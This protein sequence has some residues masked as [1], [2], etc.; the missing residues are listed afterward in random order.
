MAADKDA[1]DAR[2]TPGGG[3]A[4]AGQEAA[5]ESSG[6][7]GFTPGGSAT[8]GFPSSSGFAPGGSVPEGSSG[9]G[10]ARGGGDGTAVVDPKTGLP[11]ADRRPGRPNFFVMGFT[12]TLGVAT[13]WLLI[14]AAINAQAVLLWILIALFLAVGLSP[15]VEF[16]RRHGLP[17][18]AAILAVF[19]AMVA[20]FA[21]F[22][23]AIVPPLTEQTAAFISRLPDYVDQLQNNQTLADLDAQYGV[24]EQAREYISNLDYAALGQQAFGGLLGVGQAVANTLV[25][26]FTVLILTLYFLAA[27]PSIKELFYRLVPR[28]RRPGFQELGDEILTRVGGYIGGQVTLA[29][30]AGAFGFIYLTALYLFGVLEVNYALPLALIM[31]FTGLIPLVGATIGAVVVSL[32]VA[33]LNPWAGL[34]TI[35]VIIGYQQFENYVIQPKIMQRSVDVAPAVTITA[36]LIGGAL[37]GLLGALI[38]IPTAAAIALIL[39][40]VVIP[41]QERS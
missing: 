41:L 21:G 3:G 7:S 13:A 24:L 11:F 29:T 39:K 4:S 19:L 8:G 38:A 12:G 31:L 20:V 30:I 26:T 23:V 37:L 36:A 22:G 32:I 1:P 35:G 10:A 25:A 18:W 28:S 40:R 2:T 17:R 27:L 16:L 6:S 9:A 5:P 15:L 34:A 33:A 14:Q